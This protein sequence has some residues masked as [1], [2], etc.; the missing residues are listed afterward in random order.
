MALSWSR[1]LR[2][3]ATVAGVVLG[4]SAVELTGKATAKT[5]TLSISGDSGARYDG[6]CTLSAYS[7]DETIAL[8]GAVPI[9]RVL[10]GDGLTCL[11]RAEGQVV[12]EIAHNGSRSRSATTDG[13]IRVSAR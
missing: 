10:D 3:A 8:E 2:G 1:G 4:L 6:I 9:E 12:V 5:F 7:G 13:M 11:F